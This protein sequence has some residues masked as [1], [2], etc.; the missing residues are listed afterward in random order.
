MGQI[1]GHERQVEYLNTVMER[2]RLGHAYLFYGPEHVGKL[3]IAKLLASALHCKNPKKKKMLDGA[4]GE[5]ADCRAIEA[6]RHPQVILLDPAHTL[7]S[8]K[9]VRKDIPIEDIRELKRLFSLAPEGGKWRIAIINEADTMTR[10][11]ADAFLKILEEPGSRTLLIVISSAPDLLPSTLVSRTH[12]IRFAKVRETDIAALVKREVHDTETARAIAGRAFG[13]PGLAIRMARDKEYWDEERKFAS[14]FQ[15]AF[16]C[17]PDILQMFVMSKEAAGGEDSRRKLGEEI[18]RVLHSRL[19]DPAGRG[20][21]AGLAK[22]IRAAD[23]ILTLLA[24][25]N[26]NPRLALDAMFLEYVS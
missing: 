21:I 12:A 14:R 4:C 9:D 2:D 13:R 24:T 18:L 5:C 7:V 6:D 15:T 11:A 25:T 17:K 23:R 20:D 1:I 22:K 10:Y 16:V 3:T 8:K 19:H 26:V